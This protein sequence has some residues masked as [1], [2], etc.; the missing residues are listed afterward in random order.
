MTMLAEGERVGEVKWQTQ[1][2]WLAMLKM[3]MS[4][5][6]AEISL[7]HS[8]EGAQSVMMVMEVMQKGYRREMS[9]YAYL[10]IRNGTRLP[11]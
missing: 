5:L 7:S 8:I 10:R 9:T 3:E 1:K 2:R 6:M 11:K 4:W